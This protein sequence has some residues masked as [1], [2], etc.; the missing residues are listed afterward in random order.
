M[1]FDG[2]GTGNEGT[3]STSTDA[4]DIGT[5]LSH[6]H[7]LIL[8]LSSIQKNYESLTHWLTDSVNN[9]GLRDASASKNLIW[10]VFW[11]N[12]LESVATQCGKWSLCGKPS[13]QN[14]SDQS[15]SV[16]HMLLFWFWN[17]YINTNLG[18]V[19]STIILQLQEG[20]WLKP[21]I[22]WIVALLQWYWG[23]M[24]LSL[25]H[26]SEPTRPY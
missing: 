12:F 2:T 5:I 8:R 7:W 17:L 10:E 23:A 11:L 4:Y 18:S 26:I 19:C 21:E 16:R 14:N 9:I 25:I 24:G 15:S 1:S 20:R 3:D 22:I 6:F 13:D